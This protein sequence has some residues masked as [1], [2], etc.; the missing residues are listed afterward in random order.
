MGEKEGSYST[1]MG[2]VYVSNLIV[3]TGALTMPLAVANAGLVVA[4]PLLVLL[5]GIMISSNVP[6]ISVFSLCFI[7]L[8]L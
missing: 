6:R 7:K 8:L 1:F 3:G 4:V 2:F 5:S